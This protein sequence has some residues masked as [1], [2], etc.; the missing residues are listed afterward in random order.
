MGRAGSVSTT[1]KLICLPIGPGKLHR[2]SFRCQK[3]PGA[4]PSVARQVGHPLPATSIES[5]SRR[6]QEQRRSS[7]AGLTRRTPY[8]HCRNGKERGR[9][10]KEPGKRKLAPAGPSH[11]SHVFA[12][13]AKGDLAGDMYSFKCHANPEIHRRTRKSRRSVTMTRGNL[14][15]CAGQARSYTPAAS[16]SSHLHAAMLCLP[17]SKEM[18]SSWTRRGSH[19]KRSA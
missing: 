3:G 5:N 15:G 12:N 2:N 4:A 16:N 1:P 11:L 13:F 9:V 17:Q 7:A 6:Q 10:R 8:Q 14:I 19:A 18:P